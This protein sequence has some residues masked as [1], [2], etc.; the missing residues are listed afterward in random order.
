ME[1]PSTGPAASRKIPIMSNAAATPAA[2]PLRAHRTRIPSRDRHLPI[3]PAVLCQR[4]RA[5]LS[6]ESHPGQVSPGTDQDHQ[7]KAVRSHLLALAGLGLREC[8]PA[9]QPA[10]ELGLDWQSAEVEAFIRCL[11]DTPRATVVDRMPY[12][13][14]HEAAAGLAPWRTRLAQYVP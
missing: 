5:A 7:P 10:L 4:R 1:L 9:G 11:H 12:P 13:G 14:E 6:A 8:H 3:L 2:R